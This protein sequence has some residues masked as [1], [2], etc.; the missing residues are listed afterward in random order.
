MQSSTGRIT[1]SK[2][3]I[4]D[5]VSNVRIEEHDFL[6]DQPVV[7][8]SRSKQ[9][10]RLVEAV[11]RMISADE[12]VESGDKVFIKPNLVQVPCNSPYATEPGAYEL[13]RTPEGSVIHREVL[14]Q[15]LKFFTSLGIKDIKIG[16]AAGGCETPLTFKALSLGGLAAEYDAELVDLNY[17]D[18]VKVPIENGFIMQHVWVPKV[19]VESDFRVN[20]AVLKTHG[21]TGVTLCL[22]NW[23]IGIP[24]GR[25][26][27]SNKSG[28]R[29]KGLDGT[30]PIHGERGKTKRYGQEI[31]VS[32]VIADVCLAQRCE[33]NLIDGLTVVDYHPDSGEPRVR[34]AN[35]VIAGEDIVA[36]DAV[37]T[38]V[39]GFDPKKILHI[40][41]AEEKGLGKAELSEIRIIGG[42]MKDL[43]TR[44]N[45]SPRLQDIYWSQ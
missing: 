38:R 16:E 28:T 6:M 7:A 27:G 5:N 44:C 4:D 17:A 20:L 15:L 25:Y 24:P 2:N 1:A 36:V 26:Y 39:M 14:E 33:L 41:Y 32:K 12:K 30:L 10:D 23:G 29:R 21:L 45:P 35:L 31:A 9:T 42:K 22:K 13:T 8:V 34:E 11:L 43:E 40:G 19:V 3:L 18:S 37:G